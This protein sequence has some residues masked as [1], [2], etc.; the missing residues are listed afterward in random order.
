[1]RHTF[2]FGFQLTDRGGT[3]F[4]SA[5]TEAAVDALMEQMLSRETSDVYD[6]T[7]DATLAAGEIDVE[8]TIDAPDT[9]VAVAQATSIIEE[10]IR[11]SGGTARGLFA[12][13][14]PAELVG[15]LWNERRAS[16]AVA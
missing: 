8:I 11:A 13:E 16:L 10:A 12:F 1:M 15:Q 5:V 6:T 9:H 7:V 14:D 3:P 2:S 4:D